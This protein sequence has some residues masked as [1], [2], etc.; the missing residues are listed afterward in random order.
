MSG[1]ERSIQSNLYTTVEF[2]KSIAEIFESARF[3]NEIVDVSHHGKPWVSIVSPENAAYIRR[4]HEVGNIEAH[5]FHEVVRT[6]DS[7]VSPEGLL[8]QILIMRGA[9]HS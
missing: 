6:M 8:R 5:E 4:M 3:K 2:R 1:V 9:P 7:S